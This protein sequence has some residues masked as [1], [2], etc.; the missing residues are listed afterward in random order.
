MTGFEDVEPTE[1]RR[2][3]WTRPTDPVQFSPTPFPPGRV[4]MPPEHV[5]IVLFSRPPRWPAL[6]MLAAITALI[7]AFAEFM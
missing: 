2:K 4:V 5:G 7:A 6:A 1:V 3:R